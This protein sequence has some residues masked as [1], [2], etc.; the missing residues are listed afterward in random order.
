[1]K[2]IKKVLFTFAA[3]D[4][5][6]IEKYLEKQASEGWMLKR[7]TGVF[8]EFSKVEPKKL[9]FSVTYFSK[10]TGFEPKPS[11]E[12][13]HYMDLCEYTGWKFVTSCDQMQIFCTE[14]EYATPLETDPIMKVNNIHK[15]IKKIFV[16]PY[17]GLIMITMWNVVSVFSGLIFDTIEMLSNNYIILSGFCSIVALLLI[18]VEFIAY[19]RWKSKALKSAED[20]IFVES[21]GKTNFQYWVA[22][23]TCIGGIF[24]IASIGEKILFCMGLGI[25]FIIILIVV[26]RIYLIS[27]FKKLGLSKTANRILSTMIFMTLVIIIAVVTGI[28]TFKVGISMRS[29]PAYTYEY[30][31]TTYEVYHDEIPFRIEDFM[32]A[33]NDEYSTRCTT[34]SSLLIEYIEASQDTRYDVE[35][36]EGI[37]YTIVKVKASFVYDMVKNSLYKEIEEYCEEFA[38]WRKIVKVDENQWNTNEVYE[39][40]GE[41]WSRNH[42]LLMFDEIIV[43][44]KFDLENELTDQQK[45]IIGEKLQNL[46]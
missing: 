1:M 40:Y 31:D 4:Y 15:S 19:F 20:G 2:E 7:F 22:A 26:G 39:V 35:L 17:I 42:Y 24:M 46:N 8:M 14:D 3:Y 38:D 25:V 43:E 36:D 44:V 41:G 18:I 34:K 33:R 27:F 13:E 11:K 12:Q 28:V 32:N 21:S 9:R 37:E 16:V 6:G 30:E 45:S 23:I 5:T 29:K 10:A